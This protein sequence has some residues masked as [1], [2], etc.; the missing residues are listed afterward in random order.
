MHRS[1]PV[2]AQKTARSF[3][4][5]RCCAFELEVIDNMGVYRHEYSGLD[6]GV[7]AREYY[8][9]QGD[10]FDSTEGVTQWT[11][12]LARDDWRIRT[13]TRT[14]MTSDKDNFYLEAD[15]DAFENDARVFCRTRYCTIPRDLV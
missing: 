8:R 13:E 2:R 10:D 14:V 5:S 9:S 12:S 1:A 15:V 7:D 4:R 6:V 3:S 11:R